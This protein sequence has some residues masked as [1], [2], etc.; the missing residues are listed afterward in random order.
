MQNTGAA[1]TGLITGSVLMILTMV[2]HPAGGSLER[3]LAQTTMIIT[4]H[5]IA[6]VATVFVTF[7]LYGMMLSLKSKSGYAVLAFM[8][9]VL[10]MMAAAIAAAING[11]ALPFYLQSYGEEVLAMSDTIR[12]VLKYGFALNRAMDY[13][14]I[15]GIVGATLINCGIILRQGVFPKWLAWLG[16]AS[17]AM[18]F[19]YLIVDLS[20][21]SLLGFRIFVFSLAAWLCIAGWM[22]PT[23]QQEQ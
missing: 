21:I 7:G 1:R 10:S 23:Q 19:L 17:C 8:M 9:A 15:G 16:I 22:I 6:I 4:A 2:L 11:L 20:I 18:L 14:F 5:S 12:P 3:I 13:I